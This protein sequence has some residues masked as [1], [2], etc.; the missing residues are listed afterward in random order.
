M[1]ILLVG[2][3]HG[4]R[5]WLR[6]V[7]L[8]RAEREGVEAVFQLGDFGYWQKDSDFVKTAADC[9]VP[10]YFLDGNHENHPL[11]PRGA[12]GPINVAG[13]L[14]YVPRGSRLEWDGVTVLVVGG[15]HSIDRAYRTPGVDWFPEEDISEQDFNSAVM[16]GQCD[17]MLAHDAPGF[18]HLPLATPYDA[19]WRAE[20]PA[21]AKNRD[22]VG[23]IVDSV[24]PSLYVHGHYHAAWDMTVERDW[25]DFRLKGLDCDGGREQDSMVVL[26]CSAGSY[27][28]E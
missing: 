23:A 11:L 12:L 1:R 17:V 26:H 6:N 22:V 14:H 18:A 16:A 13:N 20:L 8:T 4:N 19:A 9:A 10:F 24:R 28:T 21:C 5:Q 7:V 3:T 27:I 15:A 2:D 25:G